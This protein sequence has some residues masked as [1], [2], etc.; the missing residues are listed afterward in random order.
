MTLRSSPR[1]RLLDNFTPEKGTAY[2]PRKNITPLKNFFGLCTSAKKLR[3]EE[4]SIIQSS[5]G[6][7][8]NCALKG[9]TNDQLIS[10]IHGLVEEQ[11]ELEKKIRKTFPVPDIK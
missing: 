5:P 11:P 8:L 9:L 3:F 1:K 10:I 2:S 6:T 4:S 7:S